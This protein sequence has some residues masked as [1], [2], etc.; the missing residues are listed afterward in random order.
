M[1]FAARYSRVLDAVTTAMAVVAASLL[2]FQVVSVSLD[3]TLRYFFAAPIRGVIAFNEWS[4]LYIAFLGAPWLQRLGGH[5]S[6]DV[7]VELG[8]APARRAS[9][10]LG[11]LLG[12]ASCLILIYYGSM[13][14]YEK[15]ANEVYDY[16]KLRDV[17]VWPVY[18]IIPVG[19]FV[20]LLQLLRALW[21]QMAVRSEV[22]EHS[23][24]DL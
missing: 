4:L 5:V 10:V 11:L 16:F 22:I 13:V 18:L 7:I 24:E 19:S 8:G 14:T 20:W 15:F 12:A 2:V 17:P 1:S 23:R 3:V 6:V 21:R 9:N